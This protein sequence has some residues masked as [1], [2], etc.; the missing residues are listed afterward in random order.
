MLIKRNFLN[1]HENSCVLY[2]KTHIIMLYQH[3]L[4]YVYTLNLTIVIMI[5]II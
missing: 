3:M 2:H 4:Y 1:G 5:T